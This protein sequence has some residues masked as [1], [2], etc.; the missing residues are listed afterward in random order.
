MNAPLLLESIDEVNEI[1]EALG[2]EPTTGKLVNALRPSESQLQRARQFLEKLQQRGWAKS[3]AILQD[4][5]NRRS[6]DPTFAA[7]VDRGLRCS[8]NS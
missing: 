8:A 1:L 4:I 2:I 6:E 3:A 7:L 5:I